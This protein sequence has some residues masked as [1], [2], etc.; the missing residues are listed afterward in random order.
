MFEIVAA[1]ISFCTQPFAK[2]LKLSSG[3]MET[4][5]QATAT[6]TVRT[7][8]HIANGRGTIYLAD[9][10][11]WPDHSLTHDERDAALRQL[12]EQL[13]REIPDYFRGRNNHPLEAG[14]KLHH[15]AC[16]ELA[17]APYPPNLARAVCVSPFDAA[18]HDAVGRA[19]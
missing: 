15:F 5:T 19:L 11:A 8:D 14:L 4:L 7:G 9:L 6:V 2:P 12:C 1:E 13:A 3:S 10:W 18:I 16:D 17:I